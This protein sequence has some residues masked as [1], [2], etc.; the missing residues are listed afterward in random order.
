[1]KRLPRILGS[2]DSSY[3]I[4]VALRNEIKNLCEYRLPEKCDYGPRIAK[5]FVARK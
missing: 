5:R 2:F 1:M 3:N 4:Q